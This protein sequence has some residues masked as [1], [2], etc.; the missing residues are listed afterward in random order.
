[1]SRHP[2]TQA[3]HAA[4]WRA[5]PP[6]VTSDVPV[7]LSMLTSVALAVNALGAWRTL[8]L[9]PGAVLHDETTLNFADRLHL[10][11]E[12]PAE[13]SDLRFGVAALL[14]FDPRRP[15]ASVE[16]AINQWIDQHMV[17]VVMPE[18]SIGVDHPMFGAFNGLRR[19]WSQLF[20][21][22]AN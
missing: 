13:A 7:R 18:A 2:D 20:K 17:M 6:K 19:A 9:P 3:G 5:H 1:M 16:F 8:H 22:E 21:A 12:G 4:C 14:G 15:C 10:H 11:L